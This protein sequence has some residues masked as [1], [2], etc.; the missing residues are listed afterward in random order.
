MSDSNSEMIQKLFSQ[1]DKINK[2]IKDLTLSEKTV[3]IPLVEE[4]VYNLFAISRL[5]GSKEIEN[6][7]PKLSQKLN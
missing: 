1:N 6:S 3:P 2:I 7:F 4:Y 5:Q